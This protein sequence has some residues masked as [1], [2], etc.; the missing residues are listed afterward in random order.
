M[1]LVSIIIPIYKVENYLEECLDS[2]ILQSY[3]EWECILV[4]DGSP[5]RS[6]SICAEY[7]NKDSRFK[8]IQQI[9]SGASVARNTGILN[10]RGKWIVFIDS[11]D[12]VKSDY[13]FSMVSTAQKLNVDFVIGGLEYWHTDT[14]EREKKCYVS[15]SYS[16][17]ELINAYIEDGIQY[18]GGPV[19]KLYKTCIIKEHCIQ[20]NPKMHY[21][22]DCNFMMSYVN[23]IN[24][25]AF[26]GAVDYIYRLL[27]GSLSHRKMQLESELVVLDEMT[28]RADELVERFSDID[29]TPIKASVVQYY[30]RVLTSVID[31]NLSFKDKIKVYKKL[32]LKCKRKFSNIEFKAY[33]PYCAHEH[34]QLSLMRK[35]LYY[36][37]WLYA[38]VLYP[39]VKRITR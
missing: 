29:V 30:G 1:D 4:D 28:N 27:P 33:I 7:V 32:S 6:A 25:I 39:L 38:C 16:G 5:D 21:A 18:N 22:E 37:L 9:N 14:D 2:I 35:K 19:S 8:L 12:I 3:K 36:I 23:H 26:V 20:F 11:D 24:S 15:H 13:I 17:E 34:I 31:T 10:A